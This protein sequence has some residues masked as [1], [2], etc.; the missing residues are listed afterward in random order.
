MR[1][2]DT[3]SVRKNDYTWRS[4]ALLRRRVIQLS[5]LYIVIGRFLTITAVYWII[6]LAQ[7]RAGKVSEIRSLPRPWLEL[8]AVAF[9]PIKPTILI[10]EQLLVLQAF[11]YHPLM[12]PTTS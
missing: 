6:L 11:S 3:R 4:G 9:R 12:I 1:L 5:E 8:E 7:V 10:F 2:E